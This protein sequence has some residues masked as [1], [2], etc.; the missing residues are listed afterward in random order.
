MT[1]PP[2]L[3]DVSTSPLGLSGLLLGRD[4]AREVTRLDLPVAAVTFAGS[5]ESCARGEP[6]EDDV[7][8]SGRRGER[9]PE[10]GLLN[11][12]SFSN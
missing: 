1:Y 6:C 7:G 10:L 11:I 5:V 8:R 12:K 9:S 2:I 4:R 3:A